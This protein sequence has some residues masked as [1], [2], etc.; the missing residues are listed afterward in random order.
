MPS[1]RIPTPLRPYTG[2]KAEIAVAG[3]TVGAALQD[4][5]R[6]YPDLHKHLYAESGELRSFV[7]IFLDQENVRFLQ[8]TATAVKESDQLRIVPSMAGGQEIFPRIH[9][10]HA[11]IKI[12]LAEIREIGG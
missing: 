2:S 1:F 6:Q 10:N 11:K 12:E 9:A 4:L 7:N 3:D 8:G 5:T